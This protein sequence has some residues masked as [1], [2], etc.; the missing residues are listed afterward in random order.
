MG[1][2]EWTAV[3]IA[4][5]VIAGLLTL[6]AF[7]DRRRGRRIEHDLHDVRDLPETDEPSQRYPRD[8]GPRHIGPKGERHE[9]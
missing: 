1:A 7:I 9:R 4:L 3:V 5:V 8:A 6:A 2:G